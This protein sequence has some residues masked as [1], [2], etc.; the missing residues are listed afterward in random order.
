MQG[1][2][3]YVLKSKG[4]FYIF[5]ICSILFCFQLLYYPYFYGIMREYNNN[6]YIND[7][8]FSSIYD[9][10]DSDLSCDSL[11]CLILKEGETGAYYYD[12]H[13]RRTDS[14]EVSVSVWPISSPN[15]SIYQKKLM[16]RSDTIFKDSFIVNTMASEGLI[17]SYFK[18]EIYNF[19][20][21]SHRIIKKKYMLRKWQR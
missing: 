3:V 12:F 4:G 10:Y 21:H 18:V 15:I 20:N 16:I 9:Y 1:V 11:P 2:M 19:D 13:L 14:T 17:P 8:T 7:T 6:E 5:L